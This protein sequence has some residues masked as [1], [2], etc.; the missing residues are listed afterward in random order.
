MINAHTNTEPA[1]MPYPASPAIKFASERVT[2]LRARRANL[3]ARLQRGDR[4]RNELI[5]INRQLFAWS[6][7][8][9]RAH[10]RAAGT[11]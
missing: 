9:L 2:D 10:A 4:V 6:D 1:A 3:H 7:Y 11:A 8:L 5:T